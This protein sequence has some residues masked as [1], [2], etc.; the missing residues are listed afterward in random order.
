MS[1]ILGLRRIKHW[2]LWV[3]WLVLVPESPKD[4]VVVAGVQIV[5]N[6]LVP[7]T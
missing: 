5:I 6:G 7:V 4:L 1:P 3:R 2:I